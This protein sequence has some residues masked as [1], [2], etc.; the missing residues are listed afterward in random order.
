MLDQR[1]VV[2]GDVVE[3]QAGRRRTAAGGAAERAQEGVRAV[4]D[5]DQNVAAALLERAWAGALGELAVLVADALQHQR[6]RVGRSILLEADR[7][8]GGVVALIGEAD[9]RTCVLVRVLGKR[10]R[11]GEAGEQTR[12]REKTIAHG[13][14]LGIDAPARRPIFPYPHLTDVTRGSNYRVYSY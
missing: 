14:L 6:G 10:R 8:Q 5:Q 11:R 7:L 13:F 9:L 4:V 12:G 3:R 1:S 2:V